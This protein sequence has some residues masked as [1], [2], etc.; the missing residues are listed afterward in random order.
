MRSSSLACASL[1]DATSNIPGVQVYR[2]DST[3]V[4][5]HRLGIVAGATPG[6]QDYRTVQGHRRVGEATYRYLGSDRLPRLVVVPGFCRVVLV[7]AHSVLLL[8]PLVGRDAA[9]LQ[10]RS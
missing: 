1:C 7:A 10:N 5:E 3:D 4:A 6:I 2:F 9:I 8:V